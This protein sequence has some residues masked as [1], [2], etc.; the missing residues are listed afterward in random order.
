MFAGQSKRLDDVW[1]TAMLYRYA[2]R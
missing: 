1:I 2:A